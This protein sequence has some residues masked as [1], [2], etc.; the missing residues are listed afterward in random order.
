MIGFAGQSEGSVYNRSC[1]IIALQ[2]GKKRK[3]HQV[4]MPNSE[5]DVVSIG[6]EL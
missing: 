3:N 1:K 6:N 5:T 2:S 4:Q